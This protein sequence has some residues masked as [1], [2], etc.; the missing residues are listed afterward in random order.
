[1]MKTRTANPRSSVMSRSAVRFVAPVL[2]SLSV[3]LIAAVI[4]LELLST[5][6]AYVGGEGLYSK[7][8]KDATYYLAQYSVSRSQEDFQRYSTAIAF[9]LGDRQARLALQ[10][11]PDLQAARDGFLAGGNDPAD[12][13]SIILLFRLF[14]SVGPVRQAIAIWTEGDGYTERICALATAC[15]K[16]HPPPRLGKRTR[17]FGPS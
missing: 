15:A 3:M 12:I 2:V 16:R 9:P 10:R 17:Q 6:R 8:Q 11:G 7:G 13:P 1:M 5:I 4:S 14:G